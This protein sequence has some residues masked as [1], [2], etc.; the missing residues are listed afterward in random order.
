M[1]IHVVGD[2]GGVFKCVIDD[3]PKMNT[4]PTLRLHVRALREFLD[5]GSVREILWC[6]SRDMIADPLTKGK[7]IMNVLNDA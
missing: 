4:E 2:N 1:P 5:K 7:T 6:D 3:N